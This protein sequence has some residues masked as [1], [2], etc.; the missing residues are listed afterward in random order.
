MA[1]RSFLD[2]VNASP[3]PFHAVASARADLLSAGFKELKER[4]DWSLRPSG[5]YFFSRNQ[6]SL[7]AFSVPQSYDPSCVGFSIVAAHTDSPCL[8]LKP[9]SRKQKAG[10]A[11]LGVQCYGGGLWHT[12]FDRWV[13]LSLC[14]V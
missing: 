14:V 8:K 5:N 4:L 3:S 9:V 13:P 6:S 2:F 7:I 12:W 11:M 1:A 10:Y